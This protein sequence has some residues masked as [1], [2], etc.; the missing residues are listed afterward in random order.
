VSPAKATTPSSV[1]ITCPSGE[2]VSLTVPGA[3]YSEWGKRLD[4]KTLTTFISPRPLAV[5]PNGFVIYKNVE[6]F[7]QVELDQIE[8]IIATEEYRDILKSKSSYLALHHLAENLGWETENKLVLLLSASWQLENDRSM[9]DSIQNRFA[10]GMSTL[11]GDGIPK[12]YSHWFKSALVV[13]AYRVSGDFETA[14]RLV[15][16]LDISVLKKPSQ[17]WSNHR[18]NGKIISRIV[19]LKELIEEENQEIDPESDKPPL[20]RRAR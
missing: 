12:D 14:E 8:K 16:Q 7:D 15:N 13:N 19:Y 9:Y 10:V 17:E 4:G 5:C 3:A 11:L 20:Q 6:D 18:A 2:S 1:N